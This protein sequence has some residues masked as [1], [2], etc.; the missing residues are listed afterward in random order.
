MDPMVNDEVENLRNTNIQLQN[1]L[2]VALKKLKKQEE[3]LRYIEMAP[4]NISEKKEIYCD[5]LIN[6]EF[7][8]LREV[9]KEKDQKIIEL[10]EKV[11]ET[12]FNTSHAFKQAIE[13]LKI[14]E[15]ENQEF[16]KELKEGPIFNS[17]V[18]IDNLHTTIN[19][20]KCD[21]QKTKE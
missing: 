1:Q 3:Y 14:F 8:M 15:S 9:M 6:N 19:Q 2:A 17:K 5:P 10:E 18:L 7:K 12:S 16:E 11:K 13:K 4:K 20:L 21:I